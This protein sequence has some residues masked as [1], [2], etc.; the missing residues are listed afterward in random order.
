MSRTNDPIHLLVVRSLFIDDPARFPGKYA[1]PRSSALSCR[2]YLRSSPT[3]SSD[4]SKGDHRRSTTLT[5]CRGTRGEA[6]TR[7]P[8]LEAGVQCIEFADAVYDPVP[9]ARLFH[10]CAQ[11]SGGRIRVSPAT[12]LL[13]WPKG[14]PDET[15]LVYLDDLGSTLLR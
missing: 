10:V 9:S 11:V 6:S 7:L 3:P 15:G 4:T 8:H 12:D 5:V 1:Q 2:E 14:R 13:G